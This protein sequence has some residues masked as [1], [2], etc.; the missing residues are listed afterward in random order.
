MT[1]DTSLDGP[2]GPAAGAG[3]R[4]VGTGG[5]DDPDP[6]R[7]VA[8]ALATARAGAAPQLAILFCSP[9]YD[10]TAVVH[11]V[12]AGLGEG[13]ELIGCST[14]GELSDGGATDRGLVLWLLGGEGLDVATGV[15][16]GSEDG[17]RSA[18]A[19]AARCAERVPR[20]RH[21]VLILLADGLCGDQMQVVR[22]A[23]EVAGTEFPLVGGCAGDDLAM[24]RTLQVHGDGVH[25]DRVLRHS[26]VA[27]AVSSD[28]PIGI[29]VAHGWQPVGEPLL[30][31][32]SHGVEVRTLDD[33]PAM[34]AYLEAFGAP[35]ELG[36][37]PAAF[38]RFALTRPL[39]IRRRDRLEIRFVAGGDPVSR[40]LHCIAEVPQGGPAWPMTGDQETVLR[41]TDHACAAAVEG[42]GGHE[43]CGALVFDCVARRSVLDGDPDPLDGTDADGGVRQELARVSDAVGGV[44]LAGFYTYGEIARTRGAG[45]FHNQTLVVLALG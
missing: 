1:I 14:A 2:V 6:G 10:L 27:A 32:S 23:Y 18:A 12:R 29:G 3:A 17:L 43:P 22:G 5:S 30:V 24:E 39:G 33:R 15:G 41:A 38:T 25:D 20:R 45:G 35:P 9:A 44:P 40:T 28:A 26:V 11:E 4:W 19:E 31:T 8:A 7:A 21:G 34:D 13:V 16:T 36:T 42:L 37:D